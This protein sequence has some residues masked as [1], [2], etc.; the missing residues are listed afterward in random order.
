MRNGA[1]RPTPTH[2][3]SRCRLPLP[4]IRTASLN[5]FSG[6]SYPTIRPSSMVGRES[7]RSRQGTPSLSF[8]PSA[9]TV[10]APFSSFGPNI[11]TLFCDR[12]HERSNG[13]TKRPSLS[14]CGPYVRTNR[15][16]AS[17]ATPASSVSPV[18]SRKP[19][20]SSR[21]V[22]GACLRGACRPPTSS[23]RLPSTSTVMSKTSTSV[24]NSRA[25]L[26][27]RLPTP[28]LCAFKTN[29]PS[30]SSATIASALRP[31]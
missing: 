20:C 19:L 6:A 18:L 10:Q 2:S 3:P 29:S 1:P 14:A 31:A 25:Q 4:S 21:T 15:H 23:N 26:D 13:S 22:A 30:S 7:F 5:R 9:K 8:R 12:G 28:E 27:S 24:L 17:L 16:G 11:L